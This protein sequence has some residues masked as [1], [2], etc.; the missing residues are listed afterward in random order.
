[1][2]VVYW[3]KLKDYTDCTKQGYIGVSNNE[4]KRLHEHLT[5]L[6]RKKHENIIVQRHFN[7]HKDEFESIIIFEGTEE[8][9]YAK[10]FELRPIKHIGW[11]IAPGGGKP[12]STF[13]HTWNV[14]RKATDEQKQKRS[15]QWKQNGFKPPAQTGNIWWN[16]GEKNTMSKECP[17]DNWV[18]GR[19]SFWWTDGKQ[20]KFSSRQPGPE[21]KKGRFT[22]WIVKES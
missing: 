16:N 8:E 21:W 19:L 20:N 13:G 9:C 7:K 3:L 15:E 2:A 11:N 12:P 18:H 5:K 6:E 14:G 4:S 1:M 10:E 22:P 17:G